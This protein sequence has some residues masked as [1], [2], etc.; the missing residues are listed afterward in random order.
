MIDLWLD[1]ATYGP[2]EHTIVRGRTTPVGSTW[3]QRLPNMLEVDRANQCT[4][5]SMKRN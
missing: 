2:Q 3:V 1:K 5:S 4:K